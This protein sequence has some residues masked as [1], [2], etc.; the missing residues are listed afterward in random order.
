MS[1]LTMGDQLRELGASAD[2]IKSVFRSIVAPT[3]HSRKPKSC[4]STSPR[5]ETPW[6]F[7]GA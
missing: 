6:E 2:L 3:E 4:E 5:P 1:Y 7:L